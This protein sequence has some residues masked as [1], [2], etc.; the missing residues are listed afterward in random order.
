MF[1]NP[2]AA[3]PNSPVTHIS[4]SFFAF[5]LNNTFFLETSP[6]IQILMDK[7]PLVVSPPI[8]STPYFFAQLNNP[9]EN[10]CIQ[11]VF[12]FGRAIAKRANFG[13]PPIAYISEIFTARAFHPKLKGLVLGRKW[14][15]S[16][17]VSIE[18]AH[19]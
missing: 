13:I 10:S 5:D 1:A 15:F 7:D 9:L 17:N 14:V 4:S 12:I 19:K 11:F 18:I 6:S 8:N 3:I 16:F 2:N